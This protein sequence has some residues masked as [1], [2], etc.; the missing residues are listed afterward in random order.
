MAWVRDKTRMKFNKALLT[1]MNGTVAPVLAGRLRREGVA[2]SG[3]NRHEVPVEDAA[4]SDALIE[5]ERPDLI[6]HLAMGDPAWAGWLAEAAGRR[7]ITFVYISSVSVFDGSR[8]GP[9]PPGKEPDA[10]DDYGRYKAEC[11]R[12]VKTA[13]PSAYI[14][15]IGWQ[16]GDRPGN[17]NMVDYLQKQQEMHGRI[18][19]SSRMYHACSFLDDTADGLWRMLS[20]LPP[21]LYH[22]EGNDGCSFF[23]IASGLNS[24][25][26]AGWIIEETR[27]PA[28]DIRMLDDRIHLT[29]VSAR[30]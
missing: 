13:N 16:I 19:A 9:F 30:L 1:G 8:S 10:R 2:V 7:G 24:K 5:R 15:R 22:L 12:R 29:P 26:N 25:L 6:V 3:W 4:R 28:V 14:A 18:S 20:E 11:E 23:N 17:N 27:E 21:D